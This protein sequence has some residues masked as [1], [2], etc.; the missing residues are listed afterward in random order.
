MPRRN[1]G[2]VRGRGHGPQRDP[3][4]SCERKD[5]F[6]WPKAQ[7]VAESLRQ[8][9]QDHRLVA[10]VCDR[11]HAAHVGRDRGPKR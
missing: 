5:K 7:Q 8:K 11:C 4:G 1:S 2:E 6:S 9:H 3:W 10:Y